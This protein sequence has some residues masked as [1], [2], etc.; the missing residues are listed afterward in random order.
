MIVNKKVLA[1]T[2]KVGQVQKI[3]KERKPFD[4]IITSN[5]LIVNKS[6]EQEMQRLVVQRAKIDLRLAK[7]KLKA[8]GGL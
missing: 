8:Y 6:D 1:T 2:Y 5:G 4:V 7:L 3:P